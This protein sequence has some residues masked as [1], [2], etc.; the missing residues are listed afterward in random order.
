MS[1]WP[2]K[3]LEKSVRMPR[4]SRVTGQHALPFRASGTC[5]V[6]KPGAAAA[7]LWPWG[8]LVED[9]QAAED[10]GQGRDIGRIQIP[11]GVVALLNCA[12]VEQPFLWTFAYFLKQ[13]HSW[14]TVYIWWVFQSLY[15]SISAVSC[16]YWLSHGAFFFDFPLIFAQRSWP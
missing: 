3:C 15:R 9:K 4:C 8:Q 5:V 1:S 11:A 10:V 2:M 7:I 14:F 13:Q 12:A 16:F 6:V